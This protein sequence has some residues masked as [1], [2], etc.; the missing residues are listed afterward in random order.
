M[1][2]GLCRGGVVW[3]AC[4]A[5]GRGYFGGAPLNVLFRACGRWGLGLEF[6]GVGGRVGVVAS[7]VRVALVLGVPMKTTSAR[8]R[9]S[10]CHDDIK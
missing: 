5:L 8:R 6:C 3:G 7:G 10:A 9:E 1:V 2:G 4:I